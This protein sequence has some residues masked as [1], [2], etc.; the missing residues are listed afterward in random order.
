MPQQHLL[1]IA[2]RYYEDIKQGVKTFE[3]R[4][5]DRDYKVGDSLLFRAYE[6]GEY[7]NPDIG[8]SAIIRYILQGGQYGI[9]GDYVILGILPT[10]P[11]GQDTMRCRL[12][13]GDT[14][15]D[16]KYSI[17]RK[18]WCGA[19]QH[20]IRLCQNCAIKHNIIKHLNKG[21]KS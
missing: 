17:T 15:G 21:M 11:A 19:Q 4:K 1:K 12:C 2:P 7:I 5:N 18:Y 10:F 3:V 20:T 16:W 6:N 9:S 14:F 13:G 8:V